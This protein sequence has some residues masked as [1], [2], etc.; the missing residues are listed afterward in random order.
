MVSVPGMSSIYFTEYRHIIKSIIRLHIS[1]PKPA[2]VT[3][4]TPLLARSMHILLLLLH[5]LLTK[6]HSRHPQYIFIYGSLC[7]LWC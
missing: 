3:S 2:I 4:P 7:C 6:S 1:F 5:F